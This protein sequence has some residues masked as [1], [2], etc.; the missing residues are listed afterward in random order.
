[1]EK[2]RYIRQTTLVNFGQEGQDKLQF[3]KIL[4]VGA[5]GLGVPVLQ[6]LNAMGVGTIGLIDNDVVSLSN[7]HRQVLYTEADIGKSKVQVAIE[8][9]KAQNSNTNFEGYEA[10]L[11]AT[12]AFEIIKKYDLIVDASDNFPTRYLVNDACVMLKK[13]F[14]YGALHSFEGHVS[15]FNYNSGPTYRCLF[16][17]IPKADEIPNCNEQGVLGI[18]PGIIG[19]LQALEAAKIL[20]E[21]G[22]VLSGKLLVF[23]ALDQ[24]YHKFNIET[25]QD[26]LEIGKLQDSYELACDVALES[27]ESGAFLKLLKNENIQCVDVRTEEEYDDFHYQNTIHIPLN[28]I[29]EKQDLIDFKKPVYCLCQSGIRSQKAIQQLKTSHPDAKLINVEG[30]Y[31][32]LKSQ[33]SGRVIS[34]KEK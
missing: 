15:V 29:E 17:N 10:F 32:I 31:N 21:I 7:L 30:G 20:A 25:V 28:R 22:N 23:N 9:L 34:T 3:S 19:N 12:N 13:P 1:M 5:G 6:Y 8:K 26:N 33:V 4:I 18:L 11:D 24:Q 2:D 27:I 14:V 16:P